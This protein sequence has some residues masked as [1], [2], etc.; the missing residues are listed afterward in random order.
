MAFLRR[1]GWYLVG[2]SIG[3][4]F[5]VF[6]LKKKSGEKGIEFCYF[7]NCR[8]L[9]DMRNKPL[10]FNDAVPV[11]HRDTLFIASF[12]KDGNI[13]FGKSDT[14]SEPCKTYLIEGEVSE[15]AWVI[16]SRNC[17]DQVEIISVQPQD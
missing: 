15:K 14:K 2:L 13:D 6:F 1:L 7:P 9:K 5:L 8:V 12:L 16:R 10:V 11:Q 4:V 17:P 3:I